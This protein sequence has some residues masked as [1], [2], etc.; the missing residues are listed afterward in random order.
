MWLKWPLRGR[1]G[2]AGV[3]ADVAGWDFWRRINSQICGQVHAK[4]CVFAGGAS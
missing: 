3:N 1:K 2:A 4:L